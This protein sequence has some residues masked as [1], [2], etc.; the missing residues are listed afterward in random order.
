VPR[1]ALGV[2]AAA[3]ALAAYATVVEPRMLVVRRHDLRLP[4]W[5]AELD[6]LRVA[7]ISDLHAGAP[8][9]GLERIAQVAAR[10]RR[11]APDL[12]L[13]LG[14]FI[15]PVVPLGSEV[16]PHQIAPPLGDLGAR[17]GTYAVLGNHDWIHDGP[18]VTR[19]LRRA[20]VTVLHNDAVAIAAPPAPAELWIAGVEDLNERLA[21]ID[22]ALRP[23]PGG[24]PVLFLTHDPDLFPRVPPRVALTVAGH[25]HGAQVDVPGLRER[26]IPSLHG[27]RFKHGHVVE[28]GRHL[29]V[30]AGVGT[31]GLPVRLLAPPE[32]VLL[33]LLS[34]AA[35]R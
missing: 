7:L 12:A 30:T 1:V 22:A 17:L 11:E 14:D 3:A 4:Q 31:S 28:H 32:V 2:V 5:P 35:G 29:Y 20:G 18:G 10:V 6:G 24:A 27:T 34:G 23:V 15:D 19:E 16:A 21:D 13:L 9:A 25:T 8:H 33:R 26:V